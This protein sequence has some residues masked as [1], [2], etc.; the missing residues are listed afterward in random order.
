MKKLFYIAL[1]GLALFEIFKVYF[2]MPMPGSQAMNSIDIAYFLYSYR[3]IFRILFIVLIA[4]GSIQVF[5][6]K[7]KWVPVTI[8]LLAAAI[9]YLFNFQIS[10]DKMFLQPEN[11]VLKPQSENK[12]PGTRLVIGIENNGEAKAYP[13]EFLAYHHQVLDDIGGKAVMVTYCSVCRTGRV[14]EPVVNGNKETFRLVGMDHFN[15][16]FED[17]A[18]GSWWRQV[19][20]EAVAG[21]LKGKK[22]PEVE[23]KQMTVDKWFQ[24]YPQ[25]KIMQPDEAFISM[26]EP[27]SRFE[28]GK[29]KSIL[30]RTDSLPWK[31][32]SWIV[33]IEV[34]N[35]SKAYDWN[36]LKREKIIND[37]IGHTYVV[38]VLSSD[39]QSFAAFKRPST[40]NFTISNDTLFSDSASYS[41]SGQ[42]LVN[43]ANKLRSINAYQEFWHS[44]STFHP[45]TERY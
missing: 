11:V 1:I 33:G 15:A 7:K 30:T 28:Q 27:L 17:A 38:L 44:W 4:A 13:V 6:N 40:E 42:N 19:T 21:K 22:L 12:L 34:E 26:Y 9:I 3:W 37:T 24:L 45:N 25:G 20:G 2:I 18:T 5:Q 32:K 36:D 41:F 35:F 39:G 10:A 14:Y 16:M 23:S 31:N 43:P 8:I 29:S